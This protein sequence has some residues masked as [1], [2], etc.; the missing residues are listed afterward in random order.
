MVM[1]LDFDNLQSILRNHTTYRA[2]SA[3]MGNNHDALYIHSLAFECPSYNNYNGCMTCGLILADL[4]FSITDGGCQKS[5]LL[6]GIA[7]SL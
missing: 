3:Q 4:T 5:R 6:K 7:A 1:N 2:E